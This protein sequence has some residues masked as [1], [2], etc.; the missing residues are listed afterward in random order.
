VIGFSSSAHNTEPIDE[1]TINQAGVQVARTCRGEL[2]L[3][4]AIG[5]Q[6]PFRGFL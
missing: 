5:R 6:A 4:D 2:N 1:K 3:Q